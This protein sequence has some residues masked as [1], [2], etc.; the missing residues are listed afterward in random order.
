[1]QTRKSSVLRKELE[2][3]IHHFISFDAKPMKTRCSRRHKLG[4][5]ATAIAEWRKINNGRRRA[6]KL[7]VILK[8]T[9]NDMTWQI[10]NWNTKM[11][12][13]ANDAHTAQK[14]SPMLKNSRE[15]ISYQKWNVCS[16]D[17]GVINSFKS[18]VAHFRAIR[19]YFEIMPTNNNGTPPFFVIFKCGAWNLIYFSF[20][21]RYANIQNE[22]KCLFTYI[23]S[24]ANNL[25]RRKCNQ[26]VKYSNKCWNLILLIC[27]TE[28]IWS[29][30]SG[31]SHVAFSQRYCHWKSAA[32]KSN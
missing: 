15:N 6:N 28:C 19:G 13:L 9:N 23:K 7:F 26:S 12:S 20:P 4:G 17:E 1:M 25:S 3:E 14:S 24:A 32:W 11:M 21:L 27:A 22:M 18:L 29:H 8:M 30:Q 31:F 16:R 2:T 5:M 10:G